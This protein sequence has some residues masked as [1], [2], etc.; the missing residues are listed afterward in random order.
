MNFHPRVLSANSMIG[1]KVVNTEGEQLG[2]IKDLMIDLDDAQIAYAVL[3]F[4]GLLGLGDKLFAIPLEALTYDTQNQQVILDVD[5]EVLKNAPGFDKDK[6][7]DTAQ[8]EAGWLLDLYE[9]YGY[10]PYW[11]PDK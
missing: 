1:N 8:Y 9:Y 7:P 6:W 10:S 4:G 2:S 3:S 5:K 11:T